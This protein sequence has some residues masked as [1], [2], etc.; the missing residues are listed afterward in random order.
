MT[1]S[2][3]FSIVLF[4]LAAV[5]CLITLTYVIRRAFSREAGEI[6]GWEL[7][8]ARSRIGAVARTTLAEGIRSKFVSGFALIILVA[9][10]LFWLTAEGDGTIKGKVQMFIN[11]SMG[12]AGFILSLATIF[13]SCMSLS[14]EILSRQIYAIASKPIPR[15]QLLAGK[16]VGIMSFNVMVVLIVSVATYFGVQGTMGRFRTHLAHEL[17]TYCGLTEDQAQDAVAALDDVKGIGKKGAESPVVSVMA[18]TLGRTDEQ[19]TELLLYLPEATRMDLRRFD[20]LRRQ[21]LVARASVMPEI[22]DLRED[23]AAWYEKLKEEDRLPTDRTDREIREQLETELLALYSTI[24]P[25]CGKTWGL[26][27][28][29]PQAGSDFIMSVRFKFHVPAQLP[30]GIFLG[31]TLEKDAL[32]CRWLAG[33][34]RTTSFFAKVDTFPVDAFNE[35]EIP[36]QC[37][38]QS[39]K[40]L[41]SFENLDP[42][43]GA[44]VFG[45]PDALEVLYRVGSFRLSVFQAA[46]AMLVPITCL[47]SLGVCASTFLS[48]SVGSLILV[49]TFI[50]S[51]SMGFVAESFAATSEY[52]PPNPGLYFEVRRATIDMVAWSLYMGDVEPVRQLIEG[53]A[54]GWSRLWENCWK[55]VILKSGAVM[56]VGVLVLR[57]RELAAIIV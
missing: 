24:P 52:A 13:F 2:Y 40:I 20:E 46:L 14:N 45:T 57:R 23:A 37:V 4:S 36:V 44:A 32:L 12:F 18:E 55:Q 54:V 29:P 7:R 33:D 53:R 19:I 56:F 9:L 47:T 49:T 41:L 6:C 51:I 17:E 21:V 3:T 15:W 35:F 22:P 34:D 48:Y 31:K 8:G 27:G 39:G 1:E 16:W 43:R 42:R 11:Y 25:A 28:P 38:D 30:A 26:D 5:M 50:L 10:P